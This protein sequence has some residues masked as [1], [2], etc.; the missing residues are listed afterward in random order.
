ML[1]RLESTNSLNNCKKRSKK[2]KNTYKVLE[3]HGL[4][5]ASKRQV[6]IKDVIIILGL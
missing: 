3:A 6:I 1:V 5:F 4:K 2:L